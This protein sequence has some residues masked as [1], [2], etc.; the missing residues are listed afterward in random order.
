[1]FIFLCHQYE[2]ISLVNIWKVQKI[3]RF[4]K[5]ILK[6]ETSPRSTDSAISRGAIVD[7]PDNALVLDRIANRLY[8]DWSQSDVLAVDNWRR[9]ND[10]R[11]ARLGKCGDPHQAGRTYSYRAKREKERVASGICGWRSHADSVRFPSLHPIISQTAIQPDS[12]SSPP[13]VIWYFVPFSWMTYFGVIHVYDPLRISFNPWNFSREA[14][15]FSFN[16]SWQN[17]MNKMSR[18]F[19]QEN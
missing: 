14:S 17:W 1:M 13:F 12:W 5:S 19:I 3:E 7:N 18:L 8:W 10:F 6:S 11:W 2:I 15:I 16:E 4:E 9:G